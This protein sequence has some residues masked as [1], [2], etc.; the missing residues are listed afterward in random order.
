MNRENAKQMIREHVS[1]DDYL[2][3]SKSGLYQCP[4]CNSGT[5]VHKTGA[6]KLYPAAHTFYCFACQKRGD[7]MDLFME[8]Y[9]VDFNTALYSLAQ[10]VGITIDDGGIPNPPAATSMNNPKAVAKT[11]PASDISDYT[12]YYM[13]CTENLD[14]PAASSYLSSRGISK[15][16]AIKYGLGFDEFS[17]PAS[18]PG[19]NGQAKYP[20]PRIIIPTSRDH[21]IGRAIN[22]DMAPAYQKMNVKGS[23]PGI[24]NENVLY[25][26][27]IKEI[28]V[29]EGA[30]DA[31]SL[32]EARGTAVAINS[33]S[34]VPKLLKK[35]KSHPTAA[36]LFLC[37][38]NDAAGNKATNELA[39]GLQQ[40]DI[41]YDIVSMSGTYKDPNERL[42][43]ER[44][45][46]EADVFH[47]LKAF[48]KPDNVFD[49]I[50]F[51]MVEDIKAFKDVVWSGYKNLD[52]KTNGLYSGLYVLA[53]ISSLGK[54]TYAA[55]MADQIAAKGKD[56]LYF[57]LEQSKLEVVSKSIARITAQ[58]D[59][60]TAVSSLSIRRGYLPDRVLAASDEYMDMVSDHISIIEGNFSCD[61]SYVRNYIQ[62]YIYRT[63]EKPVVFIDYLQILQPMTDNK[64]KQPTAKEAMDMVVTEL[65]KVSREFGLAIFA[66]SSVNRA[67]YLYPIS[68]ESLK[69]SGLIEYSADVVYG[70]QLQ[71]LKDPAFTK[72]DITEKRERIEQEKAAIPR[73]VEL[74]CLK[75]RYGISSFN[76]Y[77]DFYP[78]KDLFVPTE[79]P[80][81][82]IQKSGEKMW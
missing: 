40:L 80:T 7:V 74:V 73:K 4:F 58:H 11:T 19:G 8:K 82:R 56:V 35:L 79:E 39:A 75:N 22:P 9:N 29:T 15:E 21:Y 3:K 16:T 38:D 31:L 52:D 51:K 23:T 5:G 28:F 13:K 30:F 18:A 48:R 68:F 59:L 34:N 1:M 76:C 6:F 36:H 32:I 63:G 25:D 78:D 57:S 65:K 17:D 72:L 61:V 41:G 67:N 46:L 77:Y 2:V 37:L 55:Q 60:K 44:M 27:A 47:T 45:G 54:T 70:L 12:D 71:C 64:G 81:P 10:E 49:Y 66:I 43:N 42:L 20:A 33:T 69:E 26:P 62:T 24:F 50:N 53:A 14:N